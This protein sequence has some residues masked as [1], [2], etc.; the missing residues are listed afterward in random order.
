MSPFLVNVLAILILTRF[1]SVY[2]S[3]NSSVIFFIWR[4]RFC[5]NLSR[6]FCSRVRFKTTFDDNLR[7]ERL[8]SVLER[9]AKRVIEAIGKSVRF[10]VIASKTLTRFW[11]SFSSLSCKTEVTIW[12]T[13]DQKWRFRSVEFHQHLKI[14]NTWFLCM[15][16]DTPIL[17]NENL[18]KTALCLPTFLWCWIFKVS[19]DR[20]MLD[21]SV[22]LIT[23]EKW[24]M[25]N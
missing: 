3:V 9:E 1:N 14:N 16:Y 25:K 4:H 18:T 2:F 11:K 19:R 17:S 20:N 13:Q 15:G 23:L 24:L 7:M 12:P 8:C 22:N 6:L 21:G 5:L 10:Y